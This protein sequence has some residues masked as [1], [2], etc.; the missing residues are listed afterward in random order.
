MRLK[1]KYQTIIY[2]NSGAASKSIGFSLFHPHA[3]AVE[4]KNHLPYDIYNSYLK[5]AIVRNPWD[6][7]VSR[8][9]YFKQI[10]ERFRCL[11]FKEFLEID[12]E[13]HNRFQSR[14]IFDENGTK[15]VDHILRFE[16]LNEDIKTITNKLS[17]PVS[18]D[19]PHINSSRDKDDYRNYYTS[20]DLIEIVSI[21]AAKDIESF[22]YTF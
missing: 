10:S 1:C 18:A 21:K 7:Y 2:F 3:S 17:I 19:L 15:L 16:N 11:S 20:N 22:G 9:T 13:Q 12:L 5:F 8:Y 4:I 6:W 14:F